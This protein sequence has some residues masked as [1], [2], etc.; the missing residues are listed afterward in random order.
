VYIIIS[1]THSLSETIKKTT[2]IMR[3]IKTKNKKMKPKLISSIKKETN[4]Q[5]KERSEVYQI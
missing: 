1:F 4:Y 3:R 2:I 5:I